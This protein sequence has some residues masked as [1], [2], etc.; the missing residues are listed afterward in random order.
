MDRSDWDSRY[1]A[2][3]LVWSAQPNQFLVQEAAGLT[4]GRALDVACGE[5]RNAIWL[6]GH[7]WQAT[8]VDFS[9]L[10]IDK[11]RRL[12]AERGVTVTW[13]DADLTSW[14]PAK[15]A[16]DLVMIF[17]LQLPPVQRHA[18]YARMATAVAPGG[19]ML[20]VGHDPQ[21]LSDGYG[22]PQDPSVL[23]SVD[24]VV[25][26]LS[27]LRVVKSEQVHREVQTEHGRRWAIDAL[28][29]AVRQ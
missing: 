11:A 28:V 18:V 14:V 6:A 24:D 3:E 10:A 16:F 25:S 29:R 7:G 20:V 13:I 8:G 19:T 17:Y 5:G 4:A 22:G 2:Q 27:A 26:D 12:A 9:A 1:R 23:F 21:N 15:E